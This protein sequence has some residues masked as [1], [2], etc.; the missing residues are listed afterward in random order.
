MTFIDVVPEAEAVGET[1]EMYA[2]SRR[3]F[4]YLPNM[5]R[6]FGHRPAAMEGWNA[7]M[8]GIRPNLDPRRYE[9]VTLAAARALKSSY[10]MLAHGSVLLDQGLSADQVRDIV[11]DAPEAPL[12]A[13]ER[14]IMAFAAKVARDAG[15]VTRADID[16]LKAHGLSDAELFDIAA[17]V[18][19]RC[20]FSTLLDALG[21]CPDS[22]YLALPAD[23][24]RALTVGRAID[25]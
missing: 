15:T 5:V 25:G 22:A 1:A 4:G 10:C 21:A 19:M 12:S 18:A 16:A 11:A 17:T 24:R 23:L 20:F 7:L 3:A 14:D 9:L 8:A 6:V 13:A 2:R